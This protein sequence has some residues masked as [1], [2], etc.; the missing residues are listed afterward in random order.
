MPT[1]RLRLGP[2]LTSTVT[3]ST[4]INKA[5]AARA[6]TSVPF[7]LSSPAPIS[8]SQHY[9]HSRLFSHSTAG[10]SISVGKY[11]YLVTIPDHANTL[12]ARLA[13]RPAHLSNVQPSVEAGKVVMGGA[14][15]AHQP[16]GEEGEVPQ[17]IGSVMLVK[18]DSEDEV[19]EILR[20]DPYT[21][22]GVWDVA[23]AE[24]RPFKCAIRT[25]I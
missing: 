18:A 8:Q 19:R 4:I 7:R 2:F 15:L 9:R 10:M 16:K 22:A 25:A 12:Q 5:A 17:M 6:L 3:K 14:L 24:I 1:T 23:K 13:A 21:K 20:L 11:E